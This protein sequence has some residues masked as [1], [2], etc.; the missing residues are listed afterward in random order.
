MV[1]KCYINYNKV[2]DDMAKVIGA[3]L[4]F[5]SLVESGRK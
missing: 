1:A 3:F 5:L 2:V 4:S